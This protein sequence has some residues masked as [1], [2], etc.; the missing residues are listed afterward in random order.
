MCSLPYRRLH[1][2]NH[3]R[4]MGAPGEYRPRGRRAG[5]VLAA[6][7]CDG[8]G[9]HAIKDSLDWPRQY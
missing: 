8:D 7:R 4:R 3:H 1:K 2:C 9:R 6:R 5:G